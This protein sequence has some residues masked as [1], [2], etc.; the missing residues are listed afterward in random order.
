M[1]YPCAAYRHKRILTSIFL[2]EEVVQTESND[3][4]G[5]I[6]FVIH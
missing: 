2:N 6:L 5:K 3:F 4:S 1:I